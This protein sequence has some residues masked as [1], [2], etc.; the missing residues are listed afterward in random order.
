M[1]V[2]VITGIGHSNQLHQS[3]E[4]SAGGENRRWRRGKTVYMKLL[5]HKRICC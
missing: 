3:N 5:Q 4:S 1:H 2:V